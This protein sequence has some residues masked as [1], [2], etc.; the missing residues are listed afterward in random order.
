MNEAAIFCV[1]QLLWPVVG[2]WRLRGVGKAQAVY[3]DGL[4]LLPFMSYLVGDQCAGMGV[5]TRSCIKEERE[6][7]CDRS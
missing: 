6:R 7:P 5:E 2:G 3:S 4:S 1:G